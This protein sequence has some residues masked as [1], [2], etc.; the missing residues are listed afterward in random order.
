VQH[1]AR[2]LLALCRKSDDVQKL[3]RAEVAPASKR[4]RPKAEDAGNVS[5][6]NIKGGTGSTYTLR[7][8]KRDRPDL[9][10]KVI[11]GKMSANAAAVAAGFRVP[12]I[13][14][15]LEPVKAAGTNAK[16]SKATKS[17]VRKKDGTLAS[18][19]TVGGTTKRSRRRHQLQS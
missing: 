6:R 17:R 16:R 4:G 19:P 13:T 18:S 11:A 8:L 10:A 1:A 2:A 5:N 9:A 15:P 14:V 3:I 7:R 12:S